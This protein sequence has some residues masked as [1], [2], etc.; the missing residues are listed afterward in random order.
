MPVTRGCKSSTHSNLSRELKLL[1]YGNSD[2]M[3]A[4]LVLT[5]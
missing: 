2:L 3:S 1:Q 5:I 4:L